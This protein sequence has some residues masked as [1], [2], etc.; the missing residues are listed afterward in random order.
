MSK[1]TGKTHYLHSA[2]KNYLG[3]WDLP[4]DKDLILTIQSAAEEAIKNPKTGATKDRKV[5]RFEE[6]YKPFICNATNA[7]AIAKSTGEKYIED[8][9]GKRIRLTLDKTTLAGEE[10]DCIRVR[11]TSQDKLTANNVTDVQVAQ[12]EELAKM[13]KQD[14]NKLCNAFKI[15]KLTELPA[16]K[17]EMVMKGL[18]DKIK[19]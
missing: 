7:K 12:I 10:V 13:V 19:A 5:L 16:G 15:S 4:E 6:A 3:H 17:Y 2:D 8:W 1:K 9:A 14:M 11:V 18:R